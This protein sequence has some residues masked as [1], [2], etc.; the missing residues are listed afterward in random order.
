MQDVKHTYRSNS[1]SVDL[2]FLVNVRKYLLFYNDRS[3]P[4][5]SVNP[6]NVSSLLQ[7]IPL[8]ENLSLWMIQITDMNFQ[9]APL[10]HQIC[11][12]I[13]Q[14]TCFHCPTFLVFDNFFV[15]FCSNQIWQ[16]LTREMGQFHL[17]YQ[18]TFYVF[19]IIMS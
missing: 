1:K 16:L 7:T 2:T 4:G 10:I 8:F 19:S 18:I 13:V 6:K 14:A 11:L 12:L 15:A 9:E 5:P 3:P 17:R